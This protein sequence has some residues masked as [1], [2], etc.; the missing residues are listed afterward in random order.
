MPPAKKRK[1]I[2]VLDN[3][4]ETRIFLSN[5]LDNTEFEPI[6]VECATTGMKR[7]IE[8][9]PALI[10]L[11]IMKYRDE[12]TLL[13]RE[14]KRHRILKHIPVIMLSTLDRKTFFHYQKIKKAPVGRG[15][16]EPEAYLNKPPEADELLHLVNTL[17]KTDRSL[18]VEEKI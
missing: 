12:N 13:Y 18:A 8:E 10:I 5:L 4:P 16:P 15:L 7:I 9:N 3:E 6:L 17:T 14:L 2:F 11:D 1:K